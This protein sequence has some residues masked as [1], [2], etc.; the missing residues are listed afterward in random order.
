MNSL[1]IFL[2]GYDE[3]QPKGSAADLQQVCS[4]LNI[5]AEIGTMNGPRHPPMAL[6]EPRRWQL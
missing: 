3:E 4:D 2:Q 6:P 1:R 5:E